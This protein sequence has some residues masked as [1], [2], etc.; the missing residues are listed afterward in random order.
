MWQ[1]I[2]SAAGV[3]V[4]AAI[5]AWAGRQ[6]SRDSPYAALHTRVTTLERQVDSMRRRMWRLDT[7]LDTAVDAL[8]EQQR[9]IE[10]GAVPPPP[11][12]TR[13]ALEVVHRRRAERAEA[14][15]RPDDGQPT[16]PTT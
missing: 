14:H 1:W 12:I 13:R 4:A 16:D 7:D 6:G 3:I 2:I 10:E 9:W 15:Q 11:T 5:A 8:W